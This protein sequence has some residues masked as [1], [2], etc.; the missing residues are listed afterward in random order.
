MKK[1]FTHLPYLHRAGVFSNTILRNS[2][3]LFIFFCFSVSSFSQKIV[4][5]TVFYL[6][7]KAS[8]SHILFLKTTI[9]ETRSAASGINKQ[10]CI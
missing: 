6:V 1:T 8:M 7:G 4:T 5:P 9:T 2:I 3:L 10:N